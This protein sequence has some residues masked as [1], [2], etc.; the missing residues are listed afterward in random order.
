MAQLAEGLAKQTLQLDVHRRKWNLIVH[1]VDGAA[2]ESEDVTRAACV[3]YARNALKVTGASDARIAACHRLSKKKDAGIIVRFCDLAE[4]DRWIQGTKNLKEYNDDK[5]KKTSVCPDLP[6]IIRPLKD[7]LMIKRRDLP[8]E[9]KEHAKM[10]FLPHWPFVKLKV[11]DVTHVSETSIS[12]VVKKIVGFDP[13]F[14]ITE[15]EH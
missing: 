3:D 15:P 4:R 8:K 5:G 6:P 14:K 10:N 12:D 7:S 11:D 1:G 9:Q 13:V 2:G